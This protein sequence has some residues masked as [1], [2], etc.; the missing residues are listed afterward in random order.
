MENPRIVGSFGKAIF[1]ASG[2]ACAATSFYLRS[3]TPFI[4]WFYLTALLAIM[5]VVIFLIW[6]VTIWPFILLIARLFSQKRNDG[7]ST[8]NSVH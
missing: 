1:V 7:G 6:S 5:F 4:T 2:I 8:G 3:A